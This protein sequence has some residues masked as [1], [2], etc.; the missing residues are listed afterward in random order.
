MPKRLESQHST[1][2]Q[3]MARVLLCSALGLVGGSGCLFPQSD[4]VLPT[5]PPV[6]NQP[7]QIVNVTPAAQ[8]FNFTTGTK[9][10][11]GG[12]PC[13]DTVFSVLVEDPDV[14]DTI[15][16]LWYLDKTDVSL[17]FRPNPVAPTGA[18]QRT[19]GQPS[20]NA[21]KISMSTL[22]TGMH[23][24]KVYVVDTEFNEEEGKDLAAA[25]RIVQ[26]PDGSDAENPGSIDQYTWVLNVGPAC[27]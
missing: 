24:L 22:T 16:S 6:K 4:Q 11:S 3:I 20:S 19:I 15:K 23:L 27:Q 26:L 21:F 10:N 17:P 18:T 9:P 25:P 5:L 2:M 13:D 12:V 8:P 7:L 1:A 14:G